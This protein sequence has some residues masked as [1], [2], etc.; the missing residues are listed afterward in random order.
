MAWLSRRIIPQTVNKYN[1]LFPVYIQN[2]TLTSLIQTANIWQRFSKTVMSS[3]AS[4]PA[5]LK[6]EKKS[7]RQGQRRCKAAK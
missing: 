4:F 7:Q 2:T 6:H 1:G 3:L 5:P